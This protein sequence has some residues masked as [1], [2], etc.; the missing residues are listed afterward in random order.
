[1]NSSID[2][3]ATG[4][5]LRRVGAVAAVCA[6]LGGAGLTGC[7]VVKAVKSVEQ[8]VEGNKSTIDAFTNKMTSGA[9]SPF[10]AT[11][12]TTGTSP[13]TVL[14]AVQPPTGLTFQETPSG[15]SSTSV[16]I[17]VDSSGEY[18]CTPP[19]PSS[20]GWSCEKLGTAGAA[21]QNKLFDFYTPSHWTAF[22]KDF[23]LAAGFAGDKVTQSTM[24]VNGFALQCVDFN[25]PGIPGTSTICTTAQG[26]LGY[27]KVATDST[28]FA[29]KS[30][31]SS[32]AASLFQ[33]PPGAK[34][35]TPSSGSGAT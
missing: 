22:L 8:R 18:T 27:V 9:A 32:P 34:V 31:S 3:V 28:T 10:E 15:S 24:S 33:L 35:T 16:N 21:T 11:Y 25:A 6:V 17:V 13:T 23:S 14:Y 7:S 29:I 20:S 19:G 5:G 2:R 4:V 26:I 1:V 30:Y 12:V